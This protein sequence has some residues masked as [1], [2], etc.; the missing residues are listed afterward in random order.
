MG[1]FS[2]GAIFVSEFVG[3]TLTIFL[4]EGI[5]AN[6][7]LHSTK[8]HGLGF[9]AVAIGFGL[10][11]GVNIA[12]FGWI[13]AHLNP[14]MFFFLAI[15]GEL[16]QGWAEC[17]VGTV[18][19]FVGA[20]VGACMVWLF[21]LPHFGSSL[22]MPP[23]NN[24]LATLVYGPSTLDENAGRFASAFGKASRPQP[25]PPPPSVGDGGMADHHHP[26][27]A[28]GPM[29]SVA[30]PTETT[31]TTSPVSNRRM[32]L[33]RLFGTDG[34][35]DD[36]QREALLDKMQMIH[37]RRQVYK[38]VPL[39]DILASGVVTAVAHRGSVSHHGSVE[40]K[41]KLVRAS[42][43]NVATLAHEHD[44]DGG[45]RP[46]GDD[47]ASS[48]VGTSKHKR[49]H[50]AQIGVL[51][52]VHDMDVSHLTCDN[53]GADGGMKGASTNAA[54]PTTT[55]TSA[56]KTEKHVSIQ[57]DTSTI[58]NGAF[59]NGGGDEETG[60]PASGDGSPPAAKASPTS[61]DKELAKRRETYEAA[62][63]A[64]S[65]AK[66]SIFATRPAIYNLPFNFMQEALASAVLFFGAEMFKLSTQVRQEQSGDSSVITARE[67]PLMLALW[68]SLFI[69]LLVL[70]LGGVTGLAANPARDIGPRFA[71]WLLP[72][73][74][75]G[76]SEWHYGL[77]VPLLAP[78]VGACL[79][80][81]LFQIMLRLFATGDDAD[82]EL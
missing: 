41:G 16:E 62:L 31:A 28:D 22:S 21:F 66:L 38:V 25:P 53:D 52:H 43:I 29:A 73:P 54:A 71:H 48:S 44:N 18:A 3:M 19:D 77:V 79:G 78:Y 50:S 2:L 4:G 82:D 46:D 65:A 26:A 70:G 1:G 24:D 60:M 47:S 37:D 57:Q 55:T 58:P 5:L 76:P 49:R 8:G 27:S 23:D 12:W 72:F 81:G 32:A 56:A 10:A 80:A 75:K 39:D 13:S 68:V 69:T 63:R 64:D 40:R 6:E 59:T 11:F 67:D 35:Y 61:Q 33:R 17:A 20:F 45:L 42:S 36:D 74:N 34:M 9:L 51:L 7:L 14:G 30:A 15:Q